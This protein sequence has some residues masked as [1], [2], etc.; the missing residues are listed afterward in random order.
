MNIIDQVVEKRYGLYHGDSVDI[1][2]EITDDS[3]HYT[4]F[5]PPFRRYI[6]TAIVTVIWEIA[7]VMM[8]FITI[9]NS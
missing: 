7:K 9:L 4:L 8:N 1:T 6:H 3:I 2:K 5:S